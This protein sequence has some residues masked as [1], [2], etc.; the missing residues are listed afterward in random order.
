[1]TRC[2]VLAL[3]VLA[4]LVRADDAEPV[5]KKLDDKKAEKAI[6]EYL[7]KVKATG[8]TSKKIDDKTVAKLLPSH[9]FYHLLFRQY[10]V[11]ILPPEG[12]KA[13]NVIAVGPDGK[14]QA[15]TSAAE[16]EKFFKANAKGL[17]TDDRAKQAAQAYLRLGRELYQDG[18]YKFEDDVD[19][20]KVKKDKGRVVTGKTTVMQGGSGTL[21]LTLDVG[22]KGAIT[23]A[24]FDSKI[25]PGPRPICQ[26]TKLLDADPV[27][28]K[29]A[30]QDLLIMG[31]AAKPYLDEQRKKA[32]P[33]LRKA[34]D[35][36]WRRIVE[37]D[38]E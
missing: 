34:I 6:K 12:L 11:G 35:E 17:T 8:G 10:P 1:M 22:D 25:R 14:A 26:A 4:A 23:S 24:K 36:L 5:K 33:Q 31:R 30:E 13:S 20:F 37:A 38:K 28:R 32:S 2:A 21:A 29:M 27:V 9:H 18:Y 7:E 19:S 16:M 15:L 3:F